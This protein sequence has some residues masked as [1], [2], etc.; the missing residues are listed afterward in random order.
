[1]KFWTIKG[2]GHEVPIYQRERIYEV[3]KNLLTSEEDEDP[4]YE[5]VE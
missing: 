5:F 4:E 1:M 3:F 2:A